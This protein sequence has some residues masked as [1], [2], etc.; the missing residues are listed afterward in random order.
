MT[1]STTWS[2][3][4]GRSES[5]TASTRCLSGSRIRLTASWMSS[6][7]PG[8][9]FSWSASSCPSCCAPCATAPRFSTTTAMPTTTLS[10]RTSPGPPPPP[11]TSPTWP[12]RCRLPTSLRTITWRRLACW[13][14]PLTLCTRATRPTTCRCT[15]CTPTSAPSASRTPRARPPPSSSTPRRLPACPRT[16]HQGCMASRPT[17]TPT[18]TKARPEHSGAGEVRFIWEAIWFPEQSAKMRRV[19][20]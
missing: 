16:A 15:T 20:I 6:S 13:C 17:S 18:S 19:C 3:P 1:S 9:P 12:T 14:N 10:P 4:P 8:R 11:A 7:R 5:A 2:T